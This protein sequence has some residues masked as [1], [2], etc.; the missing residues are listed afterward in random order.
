MNIFTAASFATRIRREMRANKITISALAKFAG[1][2]QDR[3]R[4][5]RKT[6]RAQWQEEW[7]L[8]IADCA[9]AKA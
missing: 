2:T 8:T 4:E 7:L 1:V 9:K 6:G 5:L 3:V